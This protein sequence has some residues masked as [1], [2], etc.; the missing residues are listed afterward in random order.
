M[1][2]EIFRLLSVFKRPLA[3]N[4]TLLIR[5]F[6]IIFSLVNFIFTEQIEMHLY[7][8]LWA[9]SSFIALI[10][11]GFF[12]TKNIEFKKI[13]KTKVDYREIKKGVKISFLFLISS[14]CTQTILLSGRFFLDYFDGKAIV[15]VYTFFSQFIN[16]IEVIVYNLVVMMIFPHMLETAYKDKIKFTEY[17]VAFKKKT[18]IILVFCTIGLGFGMPYLVEFM[19]KPLADNNLISFYIL[20][21]AAIFYNISLMAHYI[22]FSYGKDKIILYASLS[23]VILNL[24]LNYFL[25]ESLGLLGIAISY[26]SAMLVI[27]IIK[28]YYKARFNKNS[29]ENIDI[30]KQK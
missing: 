25:T 29:Y 12:L 18:I 28:V 21:L 10:V 19:D 11:G 22:L 23:A 9:V 24:T 13:I 14:L 5:S 6:W 30:G 3:A 20:L 17:V 7:F 15:G 8:Q 1:G 27:L 26:L 4:I 2:Q 16:V